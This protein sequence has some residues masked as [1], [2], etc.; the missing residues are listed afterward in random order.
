HLCILDGLHVVY[1]ATF[2]G[3]YAPEDYIHVGKRI[4]AHCTSEGKV[5]LAF[6]DEIANIAINHLHS[7]TRHKITDPLTF[8]KQLRSIRETGYVISKLEYKA[9]IVAIAVPVYNE[10]NQVIASISIT[11]DVSRYTN[12][13]ANRYIIELKKV[14]KELTYMIKLRKR[15]EAC[16]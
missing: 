2:E 14:A 10:K 12:E 9:H 15:S 13:L 8:K 11:I 7:Y 1:L 6:N 3:I 4:P 5:I 16:V